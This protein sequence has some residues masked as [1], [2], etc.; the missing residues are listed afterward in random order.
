MRRET[1]ICGDNLLII[2]EK[3][4]ILIAETVIDYAK[5]GAAGE[6]QPHAF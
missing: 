2:T 4:G 3:D 6:K 1:Y 5:S